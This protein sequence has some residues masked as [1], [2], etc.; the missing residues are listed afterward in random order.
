MAYKITSQINLLGVFHDSTK[1]KGVLIVGGEFCV[2]IV[3]FRF[4]NPTRNAC[5]V[6]LHV[7]FTLVSSTKSPYLDI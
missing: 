7:L 5:L 2:V 6:S 3:D 4:L 1:F